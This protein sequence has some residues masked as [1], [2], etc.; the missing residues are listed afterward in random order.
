MKP[1][2]C[3][4]LLI[5]VLLFHFLPSTHPAAAAEQSGE[6][7]YKKHC[8]LCHPQAGRLR[9]EIVIQ[10]MRTPVPPMPRFDETKVSD[11]SA[12]KIEQYVRLRQSAR[13]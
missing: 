1:I 8:L 10:R 3:G 4:I 9:A 6:A 12:A 2:Y 7:L 11:A 13:N 5:A